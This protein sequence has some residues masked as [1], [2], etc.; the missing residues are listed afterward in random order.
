MMLFL[1][2]GCGSKSEQPAPQQTET[3][4]ESVAS[5]QETDEHVSAPQIDEDGSYT[6]KED[7][8]LYLHTYEK[9]PSNFITKKEAKSLGWE[10]GSLEPYAP[11]KCIGGDRFGNYEGQL[12][13]GSYHECDIGTLGKSSRGAK[14]IVYS[15]DGRI[16]Y[17]D[18]HYETFEQLY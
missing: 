17:T 1:L 3:V 18:D 8:A 9:L 5:D 13:D 2:V 15:D 16:Y 14:R 10:G 11:G 4:T 6:S 12:P 7:V